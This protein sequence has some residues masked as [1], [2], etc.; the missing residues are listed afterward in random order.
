MRLRRQRGQ[1]L[2]IAMIILGILL[3]LG[4]V[5]LG[6]VDRNIKGGANSLNRSQANGLA[7]AGVQ[8]AK[9]ELVTSPLGADWRGNPTALPLAPATM[10]GTLNP[11][12][13]YTV[14]P[15]ALYLRPGSGSQ[16]PNGQVDLGGP[17]GLGS[18][19][20]V[21]FDSGRALVRTRYAAS[22]A[23]VF[24][25][26]PEGPLRNP[27]EV[28]N[29]I[30]IE[31]VGREGV[32]N[33]NDPTTLASNRQPVPFA[34]ASGQTLSPAQVQAMLSQLNQFDLNFPNSRRVIGFMTTAITDYARFITNRFH[35]NVP[36]DLGMPNPNPSAG[37]AL[38][39]GVGHQ[40]AGA[41]IGSLVATQI[42]TAGPIASPAS[43]AAPQGFGGIMSN[44]SLD[45]HGDVNVY[46]NKTFGEQILCAGSILGDDNAALTINKSGY[47]LQTNSWTTATATLS[48]NQMSSRSNQF[49]TD[50]N[51]L[52][53][54]ISSTDAQGYPRQISRV[55][56]PSMQ[57]IDPQ[58]KRLRYL[59]ITQ[60]SGVQDNGFNTGQFGHGSGVFVDNNTDLQ[61]PK[62]E[63]GRA[64]AGST[65]SLR[66][67]MLNPNNG[68][69]TSG[70]RGSFYVPRGA[71]IEFR[72]DGFTV[73]RD[74]H[75]WMGL[76]GNPANGIG[77][78]MRYRIGMRDQLI[79]GVW[80]R[81]QYIVD[82]VTSANI[83]GS[84]SQIDF[85]QGRPFNGVVYF[86]GN[87]RVHGQIPTDVQ[88]TLVSGASIFIEGSITKGVTGN[89]VTDSYSS[90]DP[91]Y[92]P[93]AVGYGVPLTRPS[94]SSLMLMAKDYVVVNTTQLFGFSAGQQLSEV[95]DQQNDTGFNALSMAQ[96]NGQFV[97]NADLLTDPTVGNAFD[98]SSWTPYALG[99]TD[100]LN[101]SVKLPTRLLLAQTMADGQAAANIIALNIN[102]SDDASAFRFPGTGT[103]LPGYSASLSNTASNYLNSGAQSIPFY[104]M[105]LEP[106]QR[107]DKFE[108]RGFDIVWPGNS[109][110]NAATQQITSTNSTAEP[111]VGYSLLAPGP[112]EFSIHPPLNGLTNVPTNDYFLARAAMAPSDIRIEASIYAE[113][114]S[115]FVIPGPWFNPNVNDTRENYQAAVSTL[116]QA[117]ADR[118]RLEL[119]GTA[120]E[121]PFYGEPLDV[122]IQVIGSVS[123][124]MPPSLADQ[125]EINKKWGWIPISLAATGNNI[126]MSHVPVGTDPTK[127]AVVPNL[128]ISYDPT[129]ATG[130]TNGFSGTNSPNDLIRFDAYERAL[131][132]MPRLP[133]SPVLTYFGEVQ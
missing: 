126:P 46:L 116:G 51:S 130:R 50:N 110:Y 44:A 79:N 49:T 14:D 76:D 39:P 75:E 96:S 3:L 87:V 118:Q 41:D 111:L 20:R 101:P 36:A 15:D 61:V 92:G 131:P 42:G 123:E 29:Y 24:S 55:E 47:D 63:A 31:S 11:A 103:T 128:I 18:Y 125:N 25:T 28:H 70:W 54:G 5:F 67:D 19:I 34:P 40:Y 32:V 100:C 58:T 6:I 68:D 59:E 33:V 95:N 88:L 99:Y 93:L 83:G 85:S 117:Q 121:I 4:F 112:N 65:E 122:R 89:D 129:L 120:P 30:I 23:A 90:S 77:T 132:P 62:D 102:G 43:N 64:G 26:T 52:V 12:Y 113:E 97:F 82:S 17:D 98:P 104:G 81:Q 60:N 106:W 124:N 13:S 10:T 115:F 133:V 109:T 73:Q 1:T 7:E 78:T 80:T 2:I 86:E 35:E 66:Y 91:I 8:Y 71:V 72:P 9:Q 53:D 37:T 94:R 74:D 119:Y 105:G 114:G 16:L 69:K 57:E 127:V 21:G 22:D 38:E 107:F 45:I 27:G 48:S 56:P 84:T 108:L